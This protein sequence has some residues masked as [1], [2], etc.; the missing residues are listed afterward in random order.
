MSIFKPNSY[1]YMSI[2]HDF[3]FFLLIS[4]AFLSS[5]SYTNVVTALR[6]ELKSSKKGRK[7]PKKRKSM[8][9]KSSVTDRNIT[10]SNENENS[11]VISQVKSLLS[12]V[13]EALSS[14]C[15]K[16]SCINVETR[17]KVLPNVSQILYQVENIVSSS[18]Q[19]LDT[20][21]DLWW[22]ESGVHLEESYGQDDSYLSDVFLFS[23]ARSTSPASSSAT[24][25]SSMPASMSL[26]SMASSMSFS[27]MTSPRSSSSRASSRSS[28]PWES[29]RSS[30]S[31][32]I[33]SDS[34]TFGEQNLSEWAYSDD[35]QDIRELE[36]EIFFESLLQVIDLV[37]PNN[38]FNRGKSERKRRKK[39]KKRLKATVT[40]HLFP[41]WQHVDDLVSPTETKNVA[42][43]NVEVKEVVPPYPIIDFSKVNKRALSNLPEPERF[44]V[45]GCSP[46]PKFYEGKWEKPYSGL[47][48]T[49]A[50]QVL[51]SKHDEKYPFGC[52]LG[53]ETNLGIVGYYSREGA[54]HGYIWNG[55]RWI[56]EAKRPQDKRKVIKKI[57]G[58]SN[59][60][61]KLRRKKESR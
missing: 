1:K 10:C 6:Y 22:D 47:G 51:R 25:L 9:M 44:P 34:N 32:D 18:S 52:E 14:V 57:E 49:L 12:H 2:H 42:K 41:I 59:F 30:E 40:P 55:Y 28:S 11:Q 37:A 46:D 43:P 27:S 4:Q 54:L 13:E 19:P 33:S 60:K 20:A 58:D 26:S 3:I 48:S 21:T 50:P 7:P 5:C 36:E 31:S 35:E 38:V 61:K 24:S 16:M 23:D 29:S 56:L 8:K 53:F 15:I 45:L 39:T 17:K